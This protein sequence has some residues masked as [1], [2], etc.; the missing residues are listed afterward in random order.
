MSGTTAPRSDTDTADESAL[1][2]QGQPTSRASHR[3]GLAAWVAGHQ[4]VLLG[5]L[6]VIAVLVAW[7]VASATELVNPLFASSPTRVWDAGIQYVQSPD[8]GQDVGTSATEFGLGLG[9]ALLTGIPLG[10][11]MGWYRR[12]EYFFDYLVSFAYA[13]PRVALMP[14]MVLWFGIGIS[15]KVALVYSLA[16]FPVLVNTMVGVKTVDRELIRLARSF[17]AKDR[18][19]FRTIVVPSSV[20]SVISGIRLAI[21]LALIGVVIGEFVAATSG[22]GRRIQQASTFFQ[23]DLVFFGLF[24]IAGTGM[25]LTELLRRLEKRFDRWRPTD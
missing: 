14:L 19:L 20:P 23:T 17:N 16:F 22:V 24:L 4:R 10:L 13:A 7:Q 21:G 5:T 2:T 12:F 8:F 11:L 9:A 1:A 3:G 18:Q 15:S 6:G 25:V